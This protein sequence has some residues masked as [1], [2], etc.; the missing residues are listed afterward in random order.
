[1]ARSPD[2][3]TCIRCSE[4]YVLGT[5]HVCLEEMTV[6][7]LFGESYNLVKNALEE[8]GIRK[9]KLCPYPAIDS[10][11]CE[12]CSPQDLEVD[13]EGNFK[14]SDGVANL[15]SAVLRKLTRK[16]PKS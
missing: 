14:L 11:F 2:E 6:D 12:A 16:K 5:E 7:E 13:E 10:D 8:R 3:G 4:D 15:K 9:C 1:M